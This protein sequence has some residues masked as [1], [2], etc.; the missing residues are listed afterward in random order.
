MRSEGVRH[1]DGVA[2]SSSWRS[3]SSVNVCQ[4]TQSNSEGSI[5]PTVTSA[6]PPTLQLACPVGDPATVG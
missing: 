3:G 6:S 2:Y 5:L 1:A 4:P